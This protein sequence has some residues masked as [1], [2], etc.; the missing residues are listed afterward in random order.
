MQRNCVECATIKKVRAR[1]PH[2]HCVC[3]GYDTRTGT[4]VAACAPTRLL[5]EEHVTSVQSADMVPTTRTRAR[6]LLAVCYGTRPQV[7]KAS[8]L[9]EALGESWELLT[10]DT[11]QHYDYELN[12]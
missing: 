5:T 10:V 4:P 3:T 7:I 8:M 2:A 12:A 1:T 9:V 11:G 6:G